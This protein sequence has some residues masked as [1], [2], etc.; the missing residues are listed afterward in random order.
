MED[1]KE[2]VGPSADAME[3][4]EATVRMDEL[5]RNG[6]RLPQGERFLYHELV[7]KPPMRVVTID[8]TKKYDK[9]SRDEIVGLALT[10]CKE[11]GAVNEN[12]NALIYVKDIDKNVIMS[13]NGLRHSLDE[14]R[15]NKIAP[16]TIKAGEL[17]KNSIL[18]NEAVPKKNTVSNELILL[19]M[20]KN[21]NNEP[22]VVRFVVDEISNELVTID[23]L[24]A[25][26]TRKRP[27]A[28]GGPQVTDQ[29]LLVTGHK[30][31]IAVFLDCVNYYFPD[32][33]PMNV[34]KHYGKSERRQGDL[35]GLRFALDTAVAENESVSASD[36]A[37]EMGEATARM[38][39]LARYGSKEIRSALGFYSTNNE[40]IKRSGRARK[41]FSPE[42]RKL[43]ND[44]IVDIMVRKDRGNAIWLRG[45]SYVLDINNKIVIL[46]GSFQ[47]PVIHYVAVMNA[48]NASEAALFKEVLLDADY[49]RGFTA[50]QAAAYCDIYVAAK[51]EKN[52]RSYHRK[53]FNNAKG[54]ASQRQRYADAPIGFK[55]YGYTG[56]EQEGGGVS[57]ENGSYGKVS[58]SLDTVEETEESVGPSAD[59]MEMGETEQALSGESF[60]K[61]GQ[62]LIEHYLATHDISELNE[63]ILNAQ[64]EYGKVQETSYHD[65][66]KEVICDLLGE[67]LDNKYNFDALNDWLYQ[68]KVSG[69]KIRQFWDSI[70]T[71][72]RR[73]R[74]FFA[75]IASGD[76][77]AL[78]REEYRAL[79]QP[80]REM[81]AVIEA[82]DALRN[83]IQSLSNGDTVTISGSEGTVRNQLDESLGQQLEDWKKYLGKAGG[84]YNGKYFALGTTPDVFIKHGAPKV[85]LIMYEDCI[86]KINGGKHQILLSE[87]AKLPSQLN[88]PILLFKG[89]HPNSFVA[90]TELKNT[91]G[92]DVVVAVHIDKRM[93]RSVINK[94]ASVYSK[95][96]EKTDR[97]K[98]KGYVKHQIDLG[99]LI[100]ASIKKHRCGLRAEGSNCPSWFKP[101]SMLTPRYHKTNPVSIVILCKRMR[102]IPAICDIQ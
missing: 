62:V 79:R 101:S 89:N 80:S 22:Y 24:H 4:G 25:I 53:D 16:L 86:L 99:N 18:L 100:D 21:E 98:I 17:I 82:L 47:H 31:S 12:G 60:D 26:D 102:I 11:Y 13:K 19:S 64:K 77:L 3:M 66:K 46:G 34:L 87:I 32:V 81:A 27:A 92:H 36:D 78:T 14:K 72:L 48:E 76:R 38:D 29:P 52:I 61:M 75:Y 56:G 8:D 10:N 85:E 37:M 2:A 59:A 63:R 1:T 45:N 84:T 58:Y 69:S 95:T 70:A 74:D 28:H 49:C 65:A 68:N 15:I 42:D 91:L 67:L 88:D 33:L 71:L 20:A 73:I 55:S 35:E 5:A 90:L 44:R 23:V 97:N 40:V 83:K 9:S 41:L 96:D 7:Q 94:I 43:L 57:G 54:D 50:I 93:G 30:I 6:G 51:G 39:E